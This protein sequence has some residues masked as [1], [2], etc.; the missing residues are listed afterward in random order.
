MGV[1]KLGV[2][3][4]SSS[5]R[6]E[7]YS[8]PEY[9]SEYSLLATSPLV[10]PLPMVDYGIFFP[11]ISPQTQFSD[12]HWLMPT[13]R[14]RWPQASPGPRPQDPSLL[15]WGRSLSW[16]E[17]QS[18]QSKAETKIGKWRKSQKKGR[19]SK[20]ETKVRSPRMNA[21]GSGHSNIRWV[22]QSWQYNGKSHRISKG[23]TGSMLRADWIQL[24]AITLSSLPGPYF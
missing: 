12:Y 8:K 2:Y 18:R 11:L 23:I 14:S 7:I 16:V 17:F 9:I 19:L 24:Q 21:G 5:L 4:S 3:H 15:D 20:L 1:S 13:A 6:V 22:W 10:A